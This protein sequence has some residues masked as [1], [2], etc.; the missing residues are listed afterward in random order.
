[1]E[2][3]KLMMIQRLLLELAATKGENGDHW[4]EEFRNAVI[5]EVNGTKT[6]AGSGDQR[7]R[8]VTKMAIS[9]VEATADMAKDRLSQQSK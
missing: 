4:I 1:M 7:P 6:L 2:Q 9:I 5:T 8:E 3:A